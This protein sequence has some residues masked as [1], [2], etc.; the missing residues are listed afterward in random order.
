[1]TGLVPDWAVASILL[2]ALLGANVPFVNDRLF[3]VGPLRAPKSTAWRMLELLLMAVLV[4]LLGR[5][6]EAHLG[7][8]SPVRWEFVAVWLCVFLTLAFPGFV[9][10]Y[11]RR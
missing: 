5:G 7:Q 2:A 11:L 8:A 1:M 6:I 4:A 9:W 10:R 3:L